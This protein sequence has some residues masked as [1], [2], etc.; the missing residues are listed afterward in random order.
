MSIRCCNR[1]LASS[2]DRCDAGPN[3]FFALMLPLFPFLP[4]LRL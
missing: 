3:Q 2:I 4:L 1:P